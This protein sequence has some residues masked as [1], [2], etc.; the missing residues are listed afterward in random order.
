MTT[1]DLAAA[2]PFAGLLGIEATGS[3]EHGI[4]ATMQWRPDLCTTGGVVHGGALMA[5]ADSVGAAA[6]FVRLPDGARTTTVSSST[7]FVAPARDGEL[8]A[9]AVVEHAGRR[10]VTVRTE[11]RSHSGR[12]LS[13]TVQ[14]QAVLLDTT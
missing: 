12:L 5:F 7:T 8:T 9:R 1:P 13:L 10:F 2:M 11:I 4:T 6:A 14:T 3:D